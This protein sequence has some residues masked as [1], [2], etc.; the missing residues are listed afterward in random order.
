[1]VK[2]VSAKLL[3]NTHF[4]ITDCLSS[5]RLGVGDSG[6]NWKVECSAEI[7]LRDDPIKLRHQDTGAYLSVSGRTFGRPI[8]GQMEV[9]G[10]TDPYH[11]TEWKTLEGLFIQPRDA[12]ASKP[13][14][15]EL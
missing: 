3:P 1:M 6:D 13:A 4:R 7:W 2:T 5:L 15:T 8:N 14:H 12:A 10:S 9:M 11:A